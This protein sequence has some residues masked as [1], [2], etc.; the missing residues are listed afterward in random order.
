MLI[1]DSDAYLEMYCTIFE[2]LDKKWRQI[3]A[4]YMQFS[5][6]IIEVKQAVLEA[7]LIRPRTVQEFRQ[8]ALIEIGKPKNQPTPSLPENLPLPTSLLISEADGTSSREKRKRKAVVAPKGLSEELKSMEHEE[9]LSMGLPPVMSPRPPSTLVPQVVSPRPLEATLSP[10]PSL[11]S[12]TSPRPSLSPAPS[13]RPISSFSSPRLSDVKLTPAKDSEDTPE[14]SSRPISQQI[15][16]DPNE[17]NA[18]LREEVI[19]EILNTER[20]Y[21]ND[22]HVTFEVHQFIL[23]YQ[24]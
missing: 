6:V 20:D 15:P 17:K 3:N 22:L 1:I 8:I 5:S 19:R 11:S 18:R 24:G 7:L 12:T 14:L 9:R 13:P 2:L 21:V 16:E 23:R 4:T 10:R